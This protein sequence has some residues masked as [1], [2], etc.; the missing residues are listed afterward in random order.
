MEHYIT[1]RLTDTKAPPFVAVRETVTS[2]VISSLN[3]DC[4]VY[5]YSGDI[6]VF[7]VDTDC[8]EDTMKH[9]RRLGRGKKRFTT[10]GGRLRYNMYDGLGR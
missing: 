10:V 1:I 9:V 6:I 3:C 7:M 2:L 4:R 5:Q 8:I